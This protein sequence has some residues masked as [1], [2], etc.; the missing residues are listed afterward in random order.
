MNDGVNTAS[1]LGGLRV[2]DLIAAISSDRPAP[3]SGAAGAIVLALAAA[4]AAKAA[5][6]ALKHRPDDTELH[7]AI[8]SF[9]Q[10]ARRAVSAADADASAFERFLHDKHQSQA[11]QLILTDE[12]LV[13]LS[14][15]LIAAANAFES[16]IEWSVAG[17]FAAA[18]LLAQA[19]R[20]VHE[21]N[22]AE[23]KASSA[24][25]S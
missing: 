7:R 11:W 5:A 14:T 19:S 13:Q 6:I 8:E 3:G 25:A 16:R 23:A 20:M 15:E 21:R 17:D 10:I 4:C 18:R 2:Q 1:P 22:I 9:S 12:T 24:P